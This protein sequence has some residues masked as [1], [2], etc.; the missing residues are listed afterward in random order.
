VSPFLEGPTVQ[1]KSILV[2]ED[3]R[4]IRR[5]LVDALEYAGYRVA[6]AEDGRAGLDLALE[7]DVE[8]VLLD[9]ML[10]CMNGFDV[11]RELRVALPALP[12]I[13]VT[14]RG[15]EDDRVR[16][17]RDGADDYVTK[18]F[19]AVELLARVEAVLRRSPER[20]GDV[21]ELRTQGRVI[22]L[23]RCEVRFDDGVV[24]RLS[25]REAEIIRYLAAR[26]GCTVERDELLHRVW[27]LNPR[28]LATR[29]VDMQIVRLREKVHRDEDPVRVVETVRGRGY[30]LADDVE[31]VT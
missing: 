27:G 15:S 19:S 12:V 28:G 6:Q 5:G 23:D 22:D 26:H 16:G 2:I 14:A 9:V 10:P 31:V 8:L 1:Q 25:A 29:T 30:R 4:A 13:M 11:L 21:H 17:L 20:A 18:P 7:T 3:D 24:R